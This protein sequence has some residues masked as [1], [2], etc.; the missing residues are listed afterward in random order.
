MRCQ[1]VSATV[2]SGGQVIGGENTNECVEVGGERRSALVGARW[3]RARNKSGGITYHARAG[4]RTLP[5]WV[6]PKRRTKRTALAPSRTDLH[7]RVRGSKLVQHLHTGNVSL[8]SLHRP[9]TWRRI[10]GL[11]PLFLLRPPAISGYLLARRDGQ[12][13]RHVQL[14]PCTVWT[15]SLRAP[16][17]V[18]LSQTRVYRVPPIHKPCLRTPGT[19]RAWPASCIASRSLR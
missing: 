14:L 8:A 4:P 16:R 15:S 11:I 10:F 12:T 3:S 2:V 9:R 6:I 7:L 1:L 13:G 5:T 17:K 18:V 19:S